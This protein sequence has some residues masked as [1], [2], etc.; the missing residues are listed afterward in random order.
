MRKTS[1]NIFLIVILGILSF[2]Q[3]ILLNSYSTSGDTQ[4]GLQLKIK[5]VNAENNALVQQIA[6]YSALATVSLRADFLGLKPVKSTL[7]MV[8]PIPVAYSL[9]FGNTLPP[10]F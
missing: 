6:S 9:P 4:T 1:V 5:E 3:V 2:I 10:S 8:K 7:S